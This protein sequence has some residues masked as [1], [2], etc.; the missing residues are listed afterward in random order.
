MTAT[1]SSANNNQNNFLHYFVALN[2]NE[3]I[4][5]KFIFYIKDF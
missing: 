5:N 3:S 4:S 1:L 2:E